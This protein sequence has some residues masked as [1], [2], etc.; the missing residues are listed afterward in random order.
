[1]CA[2]LDWSG[3]R[4]LFPPCVFLGDTGLCECSPAT[5]HTCVKCSFLRVWYLNDLTGP[6]TS[7][8]MCV[9]LGRR[10]MAVK[11]LRVPSFLTRALLQAS[12]PRSQG[13]SPNQTGVCW[14]VWGRTSSPHSSSPPPESPHKIPTKQGRAEGAAPPNTPVPWRNVVPEPSQPCP[15]RC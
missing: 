13:Q 14:G 3:R 12:G 9:S 1:M 10:H 2:F 7:W 11:W 6:V 8:C 4:W 15:L 5:E